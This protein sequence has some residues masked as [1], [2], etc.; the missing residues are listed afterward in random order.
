MLVRRFVFVL[1]LVVAAVCIAACSPSAPTEATPH[2]D[3]VDD[4][5]LPPGEVIHISGEGNYVSN[6]FTL[7]GPG[8]VELFWRQDCKVFYLQLVNANEALA[9]GPDGTIIF[10]SAASPTE[11]TETDD[12]QIPY[13]YIPGEYVIVIDAQ[14]GAWEVWARVG[15]NGSE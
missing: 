12:F 7:Q 14:G 3:E 9:K 1:C 8:T 15:T 11:N 13:A 2:I 5:S 4:A 10:E 6:P